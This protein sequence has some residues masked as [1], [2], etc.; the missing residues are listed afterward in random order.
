MLRDTLY[1]DLDAAERQALH[2]QVARR[3]QQRPDV[4]PERLADQLMRAGEDARGDAIA[5]SLQAGRA[6]MKGAAWESAAHWLQRV[7]A[8]GS[9]FDGIDLRIELGEALLLAGERQDA[10]DRLFEA[11]SMARADVRAG[12]LATAALLIARTSNAGTGDPEGGAL[13]RE[14]ASL[15]L[16]NEALRARVLGTL[17]TALWIAPDPAERD[18]LSREA[19]DVARRS[20]SADALVAAMNGRLQATMGPRFADERRAIA[21]EMEPLAMQTGVL[22]R[23]L[24]GQRWCLNVLAE[25]GELEAFATTL[26]AYRSTADR[27]LI[28]QFHYNAALRGC[29]LPSLRG[30]YDEAVAAADAARD[31]GLAAKDPHAEAAWTVGRCT[32]ALGWDRADDAVVLIPELETHFVRMGNLPYYEA[33]LAV[34]HL[35]YGDADRG[36]ELA[37]RTRRTAPAEVPR[38]LVT[39]GT[40]SVLTRLCVRTD[41]RAFAEGLLD[42]FGP[43]REHTIAMGSYMGMGSAAGYLAALAWLVGRTD[44][45][46]GLA[47]AATHRNGAM[48]ATAWDRAMQPLWEAARSAGA[49][50]SEP[51]PAPVA[52]TTDPAA[53]PTARLRREGP[54]WALSFGD[55]TQRVKHQKGLLYLARLV[56]RPHVAVQALDL[57]GVA[58][59]ADAPPAQDG[60]GPQL[61]ETARAAY[62]A[63]MRELSA[64]LDEAEEQNDLGRVERARYELEFLRQEVSAAVGLGGRARPTGASSER[65]RTAVT[66]ALR[67]AIK[68]VGKAQPELG[69]H[70]RSHLR[71]GR[72]CVYAPDSL[73]AIDWVVDASA[74]SAD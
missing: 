24:E 61:D 55:R 46:E 67:R 13:L 63:R 41:D 73:S 57:A 16:P 30:P 43:Y 4:R 71:T 44:E 2:G 62:A 3:L 58:G 36:R 26:R 18:R 53:R 48:G 42:A 50:R 72:E 34:L 23:V 25:R 1:D 6:A 64:E 5:W 29:L 38:N 33:L 19:V 21:V 7:L 31:A 70:L 35:R 69:E 39:M 27:L 22:E 17:A 51:T 65:A 56:A 10:R 45:A 20:G 47:A 32:L 28:P 49:A 8:C 12:C 40:F 68:A 59:L 52:P 37:R 11:A 60:L 14:A 74:P 66:Q 15:E 9:G 54:V